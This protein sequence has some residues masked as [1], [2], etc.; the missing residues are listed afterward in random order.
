MEKVLESKYI[1][2]GA[3]YVNDEFKSNMKW[4]G[5]FLVVFLKTT[6]NCVFDIL[7]PK[8]KMSRKMNH[9][10]QVSSCLCCPND[11]F[12]RPTLEGRKELTVLLHLSCFSFQRTYCLLSLEL[13]SWHCNI[14][15]PVAAVGKPPLWIGYC[16]DFERLNE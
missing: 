3:S 8:Q 13:T 7:I 2:L 5:F 9:T 4:V 16:W 12:Y 14:I 15:V 6:L 10:P 1:F 11:Q